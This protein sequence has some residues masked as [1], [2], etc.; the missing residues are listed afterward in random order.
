[1]SHDDRVLPVLFAIR[2]PLVSSARPPPKAI[3]DGFV[4]S[5]P[6]LPD[7]GGGLSRG[8]SDSWSP[9]PGT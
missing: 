6:A 1:M 8:D 7:S 3:A 9:D 4:P 2:S 5:V